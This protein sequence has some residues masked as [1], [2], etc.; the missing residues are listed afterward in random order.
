MVAS[1]GRIYRY[2]TPAVEELVTRTAWQRL[3]RAGLER[4]ARCACCSGTR[5]MRTARDSWTASGA[6][7]W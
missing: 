3:Q 2:R 6:I 4:R 5:P 1:I 7:R